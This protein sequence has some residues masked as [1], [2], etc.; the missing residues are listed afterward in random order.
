MWDRHHGALLHTYIH[1]P[2]PGNGGVN[3]TAFH[4]TNSEIFVTICDDTRVRIWASKRILREQRQDSNQHT[5]SQMDSGDQ[6]TEIPK[7]VFEQR[8]YNDG[9]CSD[10][11]DNGDIRGKKKCHQCCYRKNKK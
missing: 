4:P 10:D 2:S 11:S 9:T 5:G 3:A 1:R 6:A 8:D 7:T